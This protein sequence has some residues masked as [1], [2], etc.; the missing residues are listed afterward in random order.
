[1]TIDNINKNINKKEKGVSIYLALVILVI[2]LVITFGLVNILLR[3]KEIIKEINYSTIALGAANAGIEQIF[4]LDKKCIDEDPNCTDL[5]D[6]ILS[7]EVDCCK[8]DCSGLKSGIRIRGTTTVSGSGDVAEYA[9]LF[10]RNCGINTA[11]STG[12]YKG[13]SKTIS[14]SL[15]TSLAGPLLNSPEVTST[16]EGK[17]CEQ[18]CNF[19]DCTCQSIGTNVDGADNGEVIYHNYIPNPG[20]GYTI[21]PCEVKPNQQCTTLIEGTPRGDP[22]PCSVG[23]EEHLAAWTYC[24][25]T[26]TQ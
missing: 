3:Q 19:Y 13:V 11:T 14:I 9:V 26:S 2:L 8:N 22:K 10:G 18:L 1:M 16:E 7:S 17:T 6:D 20:G 23:E 12:S 21:L 4:Y 25:C 15:G 24:Y 5:C